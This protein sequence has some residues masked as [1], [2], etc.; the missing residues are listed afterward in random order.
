MLRFRISLLIMTVFGIPSL[1]FSQEVFSFDH[2]PGRFNDHRQIKTGYAFLKLHEHYDSL[3]KTMMSDSTS[4][5]IC[6]FNLNITE[7]RSL[8]GE[9]RVRYAD[10]Q[11]LI[12]VHAR[13]NNTFYSS[14]EFKVLDHQ[15]NTVHEFS[16]DVRLIS[17]DEVGYPSIIPLLN[18]RYLL[19]FFTTKGEPNRYRGSPQFDQLIVVDLEGNQEDPIQ[20]SDQTSYKSRVF[21]LVEVGKSAFSIITL[22]L[23][24]QKKKYK[25]STY[26]K[27]IIYSSEG[28]FLNDSMIYFH[29][30]VI[31][32]P[33]QGKPIEDD[34]SKKLVQTNW[35][36]WQSDE[37]CEFYWSK[38][39]RKKTTLY[40]GSYSNKNSTVSC[41]DSTVFHGAY[42]YN[43]GVVLENDK[44][45]HLLEKDGRKTFISYYKPYEEAFSVRDE[46]PQKQLTIVMT[47][48]SDFIE[49]NTYQLKG[50]FMK[51]VLSSG[52]STSGVYQCITKHENKEGENIYCLW[53]FDKNGKLLNPSKDLKIKPIK[54]K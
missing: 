16:T 37:D 42:S 39:N 29:N 6:D 52:F 46:L 25:T 20:L 41:V 36:N 14:W 3:E 32:D 22:G 23:Y 21:G 43:K 35:Y 38:K 50:A 51:E 33:L 4:L 10:D 47:T 49:G 5:Y 45:F 54:S 9:W 27:P 53:K 15:F 1:N 12:L 48:K 13:K 2:F 19:S 34:L 24:R 26:H 7:R 8:S 31:V 18:D 40:F 17:S 44:C 11:G 30:G 28:V